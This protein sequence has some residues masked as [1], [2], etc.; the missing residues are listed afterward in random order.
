MSWRPSEDSSVQREEKNSFWAAIET[1]YDN[2]CSLSALPRHDHQ[3]LVSDYVLT[4][5]GDSG[6][7]TQA[8]KS[9]LPRALRNC[10][11]GATEIDLLDF[12][13][14]CTR[15]RVLYLIGPRGAGKTSLLHYVESV[16]Q[17]SGYARFPVFLNFNCL[18]LRNKE[19]TESD[20]VEI[21][22]EE[23]SDLSTKEN[24]PPLLAMPLKKAV[25]DIGRFQSIGDA[26]RAVVEVSRSLTAAQCKRLILVFDN[27]DQ[28]SSSITG[29]VLDLA[30]ELHIASSLACIV[31]LRPATQLGHLGRG[32]ARA[33]ANYSIQ[34]FAPRVLEWLR[35]LGD[36]L[37]ESAR[38]LV[39]ENEAP[40]EAYG[41]E[42]QP[43]DIKRVM[44]GFIRVL[45]RRVFD[46]DVVEILD[47][48]SS[49][50]TRHLVRLVRKLLAHRE[51]PANRLMAEEGVGEYHPLPTMF[52]GERCLFKGDEY[53]PNLLC[54]YR[55]Q[56]DPDFLISHRLLSLLSG[57][58][59]VKTDDV[60][61]FLDELGYDRWD[62]IA[63][64][65]MLHRS[66]LI[67]PSDVDVIDAD[68]ALPE[69]V[70]ISDAGSYY[71]NH[72]LQYTDYL[73]TAVVDVPLEHSLF[74]AATRRRIQE[75][76]F[77][78]RLASL[79]E[80]AQEV[81]RLE[82]LQVGKLAGRP[83]SASLRRIAASLRKGRLLTHSLIKGLEAACTRG[84][85]S[86]SPT[87]SNF[88]HKV[89]PELARLKGWA[90]S[91]EKRLAEIENK[92]RKA[93]P[94][95]GN[96]I[97]WHQGGDEVVLHPETVG[98]KFNLRADIHSTDPFG[99]ALIGVKGKVGDR[100]YFGSTLASSKNNGTRRTTK[101]ISGGQQNVKAFLPGLDGLPGN[102]APQ[103]EPQTLPFPNGDAS[104]LGLLSA[105]E[106][107]GKLKV[108][109]TGPTMSS[110]IE[111]K[112]VDIDDLVGWARKELDEVGGL[113]VAN[114]P[115][116]E[117]IMEIGTQLAMKT[118]TSEGCNALASVLKLVDTVVFYSS[119]KSLC[120]PWEWLR[121][122]PRNDNPQIIG[123][124]CRTIRW[125]ADL[126]TGSLRLHCARWDV[127]AEPLGTLG[128]KD[129]AHCG[130]APKSMTDL[131]DWAKPYKTLHL[132]GHHNGE[133]LTVS[134]KVKIS[135]RTAQSFAIAG[136]RS[137]ILSGCGTASNR[138][139]SNLA[140]ALAMTSRC[141]VWGPLVSITDGIA[142]AIDRQLA[143]VCE[144]S[145][146]ATIDTFMKEQRASMPALRLYARF[147]LYT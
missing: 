111:G 26:R 102:A 49:D 19:A 103:L 69:F 88:V 110:S 115:F 106:L 95:S 75:E 87:V 39:E 118:L 144:S 58:P 29:R 52:E 35:V 132:V 137:I 130:S 25:H 31:C 127:S 89:R 140:A 46:D 41:K 3:V 60:F 138:L 61:A 74:R 116:E 33:F 91:A 119:G 93:A 86:R 32:D 7:D 123:D 20:I 124:V 4:R 126:L 96:P 45:T 16:A 79:L 125:P 63:C 23:M 21:L 57:L 56:G 9:R 120:L 13:V 100:S 112:E 117:R 34:V 85:A 67:R 76:S 68:R 5:K 114:E 105:N 72:I 73:V 107:N 8:M 1:A 51:F 90:E 77:T 121:P 82:E 6:H 54:L 62:V 24:V 66:L 101:G 129:G 147:G 12:V 36:R 27:V 64:M 30:R 53:T 80:F 136:P 92:G 40:L 83:A 141:V 99:A 11:L 104:R 133:E 14:N 43:G 70:S 143:K 131:T 59:S 128:L 113:V 109:F 97:R 139:E 98:D 122:P 81:R 50:D 78:P 108:T 84:E 15:D 65:D 142:A 48:V 17:Q 55:R 38:A 71:L 134:P 145:K 37:E 44:N 10:P 2:A 42:L 22:Y 94:L 28:L 47:A 146:G 135:V 18:S